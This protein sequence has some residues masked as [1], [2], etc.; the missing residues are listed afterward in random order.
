M[1]AVLVHIGVRI[2]NDERWGATCQF[3]VSITTYYDR[4]APAVNL[5]Y[6]EEDFGIISIITKAAFIYAS[7]FLCFLPFKIHEACIKKK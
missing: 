3:H 1:I 7:E 4:F 2:M 6:F 5:L